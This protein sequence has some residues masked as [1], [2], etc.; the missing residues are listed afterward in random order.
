MVIIAILAQSNPT[1]LGLDQ[2]YLAWPLHLRN[3]LMAAIGRKQT[4]GSCFE[5]WKSDI[6]AENEALC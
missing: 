5:M 1:P 6:V 3:P 2:H 4:L